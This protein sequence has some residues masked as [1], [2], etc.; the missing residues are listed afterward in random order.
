[1][2]RWQAL[3][4]RK[5]VR[6]WRGVS[7]VVFAVVVGGFLLAVDWPRVIDT[8]F[9]PELVRDQFMGILTT[10]AKNTII[11]TVLGFSGGLVLG[12]GLA[13]MRLSQS[14]PFRWASATY[15]DV[16]RGIPLLLWILLIGLGLPIALGVRVP[17]T[18]GPGAI[19]LSLVAGAYMAETIR[20]GIGAVDRGQM[21]AARSLGM[22]HTMSM[23]VIIL[24]QAFRLMIPPL[25][26]EF[27]LLLKDTSLVSAIG[28]TLANKELTRWGREGVIDNANATPLVV[29]GLVYLALTIPLTRLVAQLEK[30]AAKGK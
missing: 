22:G 28:V 11:F 26:N 30:R 3:S 8:M 29:A 21:E 27:V 15:I 13:L 9:R 17:G 20:A 23:L 12:L 7:Y 10:A 25:T 6:L 18:Y 4:K 16:V 19:A 24:P 2:N 1:V 5:K 14:A